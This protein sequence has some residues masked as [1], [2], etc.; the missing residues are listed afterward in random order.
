MIR[1]STPLKHGLL[2]IL[3]DP[4]QMS[5]PGEAPQRPQRDSFSMTQGLSALALTLPEQI[6]LDF[7]CLTSRSVFLITLGASQGRLKL[8]AIHLC[9]LNA[10]Y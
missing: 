2:L 9:L 8:R 4:D 7:I 5:L 10:Q 6:T 3:E 1:N